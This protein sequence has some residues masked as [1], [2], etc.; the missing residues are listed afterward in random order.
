MAKKIEI[1]YVDYQ[2]SVHACERIL[3]VGGRYKDQTWQLSL[4]AAVDAIENGIYAFYMTM[5]DSV[6]DIAVA[7]YKGK[8]YLRTSGDVGELHHLLMLPSC[9]PP[10]KR[11]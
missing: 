10:P 1:H 8:K 4:Q 5:F 7:A 11:R 6:H 3:A 9:P 2:S